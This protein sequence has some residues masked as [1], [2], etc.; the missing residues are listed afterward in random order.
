MAAAAAAAADLG[1]RWIVAQVSSHNPEI[2]RAIAALLPSS[3]DFNATS[4]SFES[5]ATPAPASFAEAVVVFAATLIVFVALTALLSAATLA[6]LAR[7][8][9]PP[10]LGRAAVARRQRL[11][12]WLQI[13]PRTSVFLSVCAIFGAIAW[14]AATALQETGRTLAPPRVLATGFLAY[15]M[16]WAALLLYCLGAITV[17]AIPRVRLPALSF[18]L[19]SDC[20][21]ELEPLQVRC[22][23]CGWNRE[24]GP[25]SV[26]LARP[27]LLV[28]FAVV[29]AGVLLTIM[30]YLYYPLQLL[31][32]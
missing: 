4:F 29:S 21:H 28:G 10:S 24:G 30:P 16:S 5:I 9:R 27:V 22:P 15:A 8:G 6:L 3:T 2:V 20:G 19:C 12:I 26:R 31:V 14:H 18:T 25:A 23:E 11:L 1:V 13:L 17:A 7:A 32:G